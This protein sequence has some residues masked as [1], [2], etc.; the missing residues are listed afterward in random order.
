MEAVIKSYL[1][2]QL[3]DRALEIALHY[4]HLTIAR[5]L[6]RENAEIAL[7][8]FRSVVDINP[9]NGNGHYALAL[10]LIETNSASEATIFLEEALKQASMRG[11]NSPRV[12]YIK[13][14]LC[15]IPKR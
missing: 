12:K 10:A 13:E 2:V 9:S 6:M 5:K 15:G 3:I 11:P 7:D 1:R 4:P 8:Y 14:L